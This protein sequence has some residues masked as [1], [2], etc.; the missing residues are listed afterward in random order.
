MLSVTRLLLGRKERYRALG[1]GIPAEA[2]VE[3]GLFVIPRLMGNASSMAMIFTELLDQHPVSVSATA[4][5]RAIR[6][7]GLRRFYS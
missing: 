6:D 4:Y 7:L 5:M 3:V 2:L 1:L